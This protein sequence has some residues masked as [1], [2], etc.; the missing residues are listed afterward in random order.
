MTNKFILDACCGAKMFWNNKNQPNTIFIDIRREEKG[1][2]DYRKNREIQ[3]DIIMDFRKLD[4]PDK[5]FKLVCFDPPHILSASNNF[6]MARDYGI[7]NKDTWKEDIK[8]GFSECWR[9]L[10]DYGTLTFKWNETSIKRKEILEV[11]KDWDDFL[12]YGNLMMSKIPT[13][14]F[15]FMKIPK[16]LKNEK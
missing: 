3:P 2:N 14:W 5:S 12:L 11:L 4:F 1:Y 7:L 16:E 15:V 8:K 9:V 6:R 10:D 13:H